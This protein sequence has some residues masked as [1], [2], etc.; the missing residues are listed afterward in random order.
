MLPCYNRNLEI[1]N[2]TLVLEQVFHLILQPTVFEEHDKVCSFQSVAICHSTSQGM[3][4]IHY[5]GLQRFCEETEGD[6]SLTFKLMLHFMSDRSQTF[7]KKY[8]QC[9]CKFLGEATEGCASWCRRL[10]L[11]V[12]R[13]QFRLPSPPD[14]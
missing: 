5:E 2:H 11:L 12:P 14:R 4:T 6:T 3:T 1:A 13:A 7:Y 9:D 10:R 8:R